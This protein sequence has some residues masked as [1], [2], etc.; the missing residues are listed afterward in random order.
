M[1]KFTPNHTKLHRSI[2]THSSAQSFLK[3]QL[4]SESVQITIRVC[5]FTP[6]TKGSNPCYFLKS[7]SINFYNECIRFCK[8][9]FTFAHVTKKASAFKYRYARLNLPFLTCPSSRLSVRP[10]TCL[11]VCPFILQ[12][13]C[14]FMYLPIC[15]FFCM[16]ASKSVSLSVC[17]S[18]S[19]SVCQSVSL[20]VCQ[21]VSLSVCQSVSLSVCQSVSPSPRPL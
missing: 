21:S 2:T 15:L 1:N 18:V 12:S 4:F 20:S 13:V 5:K 9:M 8:D 11:S 14:S 16:Q 7:L 17:Q 3:R 10:S 19:L 6:K